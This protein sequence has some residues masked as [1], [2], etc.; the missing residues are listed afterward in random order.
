M[1]MAEPDYL[2]AQRTKRRNLVA[3]HL[4]ELGRG[5]LGALAPQRYWRDRAGKLNCRHGVILYGV[6]CTQCEREGNSGA[7]IT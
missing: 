7:G 3:H 6:R 4:A 2:E 1:R 5:R